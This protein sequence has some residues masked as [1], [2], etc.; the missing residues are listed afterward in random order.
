MNQDRPPEPPVDPPSE[1]ADTPVDDA[2]VSRQAR[3]PL[4]GTPCVHCGAATDRHLEDGSTV[5]VCRTCGRR[6]VGF[7]VDDSIDLDIRPRWAWRTP[8]DRERML[9]YDKLGLC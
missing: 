4:V 6:T 3:P 2:E 9:D 1:P 5:D 7:V 8:Q